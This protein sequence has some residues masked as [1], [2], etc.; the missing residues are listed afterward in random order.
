PGLA[1]AGDGEPRR[2][3]G[4]GGR[5][6]FRGDRVELAARTV[7]EERQRDVELLAAEHTNAP[8]A[9]EGAALP[10]GQLLDGLAGQA[11]CTEQAQ[12]FTAFDASKD[13]H[14]D[15]SRLCDKRRRTR[16]STATAARA[17]TVSRSAGTLNC[18]ASSPSGPAACRYTSPTGFSAVPPP[19]P[20]MPVSET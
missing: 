16:C 11:Q 14:T 7:T 20:A 10:A 17:R 6:K 18:A 5:P 12:A 15:S 2:L 3:G 8:D 19:G 4:M 1:V 9:G 13:V